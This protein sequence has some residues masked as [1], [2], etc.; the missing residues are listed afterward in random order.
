MS[1]QGLGLR[2]PNGKWIAFT[3][4]ISLL[5]KALFHCLTFTIHTHIHGPTA[6]MQGKQPA[7]QVLGALLRDTSTLI[8]ARAELRMEPATYLYLLNYCCPM[9]TVRLRTRGFKTQNSLNLNLWLP[10]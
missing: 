8:L 10:V 6:A 4:C 2:R 3:Y 1:E 5:S 7:H 9:P